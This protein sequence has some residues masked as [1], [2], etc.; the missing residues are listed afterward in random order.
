MTIKGRAAAT[1]SATDR[2]RCK[3]VRDP[4]S[5]SDGTRFLVDGLWPR[6]VRKEDVHVSAWLRDVAPSD[7]LRRWFGHDPE[8]WSGFRR[9][10]FAELD[11]R[12]DALEPLR[13]AARD[14][15]V[16]LVFGSRER[17]HNN[18]VALAQ[19]LRRRLPRRRRT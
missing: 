18:A 4:A 2:I 12:R 7:E 3:H 9:R 6:G 11:E 16:T 14:G 10:Y 15:V 17:E 13:A 8:R 5:P 19:Y 1:R